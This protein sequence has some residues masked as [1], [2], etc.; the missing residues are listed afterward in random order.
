MDSH[1]SSICIA[2]SSGS[3]VHSCGNRTFAAE[4]DS[5]ATCRVSV[6]HGRNME[7]SNTLHVNVCKLYYY[8]TSFERRQSAKNFFTVEIGRYSTIWKTPPVFVAM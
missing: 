4:P 6:A 3:F 1:G 7:E 5:V 2:A 8:C